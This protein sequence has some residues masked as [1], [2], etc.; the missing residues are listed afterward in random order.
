MATTKHVFTALLIG[1]AAGTA[2][3]VLF[4]PKSGKKTRRQIQDKA[5]DA[6]DELECAIEKGEDILNNLKSKV[7]DKASAVSSAAHEFKK[8]F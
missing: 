7:K 4:A 2:L 6:L 5:E 1:A 8:A 3:G